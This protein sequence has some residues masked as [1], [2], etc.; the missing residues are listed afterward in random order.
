MSFSGSGH[1][2]FRA[3]SA[4]ERGELRSKG[5]VKK[6]I[7]FNASDENIELLLRTVIS[8]HQ[9]SVYGAIADVCAELPKDLGAPGNLQHLIIWK[10]WRFPPTSLLQKILPMHRSGETWC[11]NRSGNWNKCQ[12]TRNY[13]NYVLMLV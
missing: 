7:H 2:I 12:K 5:G 8:A 10:R 13:P 6:P 3:S 4:F 1:P 11:K 9:L